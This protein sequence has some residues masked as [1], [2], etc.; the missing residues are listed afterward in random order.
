MHTLPYYPNVIKTVVA[1][2]H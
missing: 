1:N 2:H